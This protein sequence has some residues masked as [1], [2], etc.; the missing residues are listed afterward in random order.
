MPVR[1]APNQPRHFYR[2]GAALARFRGLPQASPFTPEDWV[3]STVSRF[4]TDDVGL[5]RLDDGRFLRDALAADPLPFLGAAHLARSGADP[6]VLVKLLDPGQRIPVH[7][8]PDRAFAARHLGLGH[9]KTEA[10]IVLEVRDPDACVYLGFRESV[11]R[12]DLRTWVREQ[13][14]ARLLGALNGMPVAPG[15][16]F[17][18][19]AGVPHAIGA[20]LLLLELQEPTDL[21]V[22]MEW[23]DLA[24]DGRADGHLGL[25]FDLAL[26]CVDRSALRGDRLE[27]LWRG[28]RSAPAEGIERVFPAPVD[29]F[30]RAEWIGVDP[31]VELDPAYAILV[32]LSGAGSLIPDGSPA[33]RVHRGDT[34]LIPFAAG[35]CRI[36]GRL[37]AIR[38]LPPVG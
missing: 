1:L 25:G 37:Q 30:F 11:R 29:A 10:W 17:F 22:L 28:R 16:A 20:G 19:P 31:A 33:V 27:S 18:V 4:G 23:K 7:A 38:C 24:V 13:D 8:H 12:E 32:V 26:E 5:T 34:L 15:S 14:V 2:G 35:R 6:G 21:S 9:G 3:G 36:E